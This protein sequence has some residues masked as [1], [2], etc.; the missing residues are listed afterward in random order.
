MAARQ[1]EISALKAG[2]PLPSHRV[3]QLRSMGMHAVRFEFVVR[4]LRSSIRVDTLSIYWEQG[5]DFMLR[6][7]V[8]D[9]R[10]RLVIGRRKHVSGEFLDL[11]LLCYPDDAEVK[12]LVE[13]EID[14]MVARVNAQDAPLSDGS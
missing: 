3:I 7:Q 12:Q 9:V 2:D 11:W 5:T 8:E 6:P 14:L 10:R 1:D 13:R 4:L